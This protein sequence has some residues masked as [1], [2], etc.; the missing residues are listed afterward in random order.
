MFDLKLFLEDIMKSQKN[1]CLPYDSLSR[2]TGIDI[3]MIDKIEKGKVSPT[4]KQID[5]LSNALDLNPISYFKI[6]QNRIR[7]FSKPM[8][9]AVAG[10]G[11]VGLSLAVL[12]AQHNHVTAVDIVEEKVNKI[13]SRISP[14]QDDYIEKYLAEKNWI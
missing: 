9:I 2:I 10:T 11:Y 3:A 5:Q 14:I 6:S 1:K 13:N 12:L 7:N 8:R 4:I